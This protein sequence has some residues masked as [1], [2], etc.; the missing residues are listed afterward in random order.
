MSTETATGRQANDLTELAFDAADYAAKSR[1]AVTTAAYA[2]D[3]A[4]FAS[5]ATVRDL[6]ALPAVADTVSLYLTDLAN[7]GRKPSTIRRRVASISDAH[8][9]AGMAN[10]TKTDTIRK[11]VTGIARAA[12]ETAAEAGDRSVTR[13]AQALDL[14]AL[15]RIVASIDTSTPKGLRDRALLVI[16]FAGYF[17]RSEL[18]GLTV[19]ALD[20]DESGIVAHLT[21]SKT[22]QT[23]N[24]TFR[25]MRK[26]STDLDPV[27]ALTA[28]LDIA[29]IESGPIFRAVDRHGNIAARS[30]SDRAVAQ[31]L[32]AR[33]EAAGIDP[34]AVSGHSLRRGAA[35]TAHRN[36]AD[37]LTIAR[38]GG[39]ADGSRT[40][41]L[42]IE[43]A[44]A[45]TEAPNLGL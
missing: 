37:A 9:T 15:A 17:R 1:S 14:T 3:W 34:A 2:R 25:A 19:E 24:G 40:L 45:L 27:A 44:E 31:T 33:A 35:T 39:W 6:T 32:K 43:S 38:A 11:L 4:D 8:K 22:D 42:Y 30:M 7:Q 5:W 10:P 26:G 13:Q 36:G 18:V 23:G 20:L 41:H 16:G 28:W 21:T 12:A 29:G